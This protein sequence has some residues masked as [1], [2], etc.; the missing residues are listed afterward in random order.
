MTGA[1]VVGLDAF[2]PAFPLGWLVL[3]AVCTIGGF[4][5]LA[6]R[7]STRRS[8]PSRSVGDGRTTPR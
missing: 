6:W 3:G 2:A 5:T 8:T 1:E 4:A 7:Q